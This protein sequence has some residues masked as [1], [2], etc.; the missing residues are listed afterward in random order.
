[1]WSLG[2]LSWLELIRRT[3]RE[4]WEDEVF[5]QAAR[6]AFYHFIALFPCLLLAAAL[7]ARMS[8]T[9]SDLLATLRSSLQ[10]ILPARASGMVVGVMDEI[11]RGAARRTVWFSALGSLWAAFNGTWAVMAGLNDAY[12]VVEERPWWK[13]TLIAAG[14]TTALAALGFAALVALFY[15]PSAG[16]M[17]RIVYWLIAAALL[18][19]AFALFYRFAPD[20]HGTPLQWTT[21]G[22]VAGVALWGLATALFRA[23]VGYAAAKYDQVYGAMAA[24]AILLLWFYFTGAAIL[25]GGEM[26]SEIENAAAQNGHPDARRPGERRAGGR[27]AAR[28]S[29]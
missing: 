26:N 3:W 11:R 29:G 12:E 9:G 1:M 23:Y 21:P 2:G 25:I 4:S 20:L 24:A 13:I 7:L 27:P 17:G 10:A 19:A 18:M 8:H 22:T 5:G 16:L 28:V 15:G 6:L 14:L